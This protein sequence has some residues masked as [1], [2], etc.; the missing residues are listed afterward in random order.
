MNVNFRILWLVLCLGPTWSIAQS[1]GEQH[2]S[3]IQAQAPDG[4][5]ATDVAELTI[6]DQYQSQHNG[7]THLYAKQEYQGIAVETGHYSAHFDAEGRLLV[8]HNQLEKNLEAR[9]PTTQPT[10]TAAQAIAVAAQDLERADAGPARLLKRLGGEAQEAQ[11]QNEQLSTEPIPVQLSFLADRTGQMH[12]AWQLRL[13]LPGQ[14]HWWNYW[15]D[16]QDGSVVKRHDW[17][18]H[19]S[20]GDHS[21][22]FQEREAQA[23]TSAPFSPYAP[24]TLASVTHAQDGSSYRILPA[25]AESP[26]HGNFEL[27]SE[28]ADSLA[29]P[30]GWHDTDGQVGPEFTTTRGNNVYA[31]EDRGAANELTGYSPDGGPGLDF[32]FPYDSSQG[33]VENQDAAITNLFYWNNVMHDVWYHLGFDE[34]AGNFQLTNYGRGGTGG[35]PVVADAQDG[36]GFNNANFATPPDGNA[37]RMQMFIWNPELSFPFS[38]TAPSSLAGT[39]NSQEAALGPDLT[40]IPLEGE[41]VLMTSGGS[42]EGCGPADNPAELDGKI[43]LIRRGSCL[44]VDKILNAQDA[45]AIAV[46]MINNVNGDPIAMGGDDP[47]GQIRIPSLMITQR[48]GNLL[49][50]NLSDGPIMGALQARKI[51]GGFD[52]DFDN[53]VIAHE[54]AHGISNRLTG[55]PAEAFG[56]TNE[57]QA[58]EGWS[59]WFGLVVTHRPGDTRNTAR[60][61]ATYLTGERTTGNGI[62]P[63]RYSTD[64]ST[65]TLTYDDI[66]RLSVPHG[67]GSVMATMLWDL[68]W[69]LIDEYGF[70]PN[71]RDP[72]AGNVKAMQLVMDGLKLQAVSPGFTDVRD[73]ILLADEVNFNGAHHC[74]IWKTFARRGLGYSADQGSV[75]DRSDGSEAFDLPPLCQETIF[76]TNSNDKQIALPGDTLSYRVIW[77]N[78]TGADVPGLQVE[79]ELASSLNSL[80]LQGDCVEQVNGQ[81]LSF[82]P[83]VLLNE[84]RDTCFFLT[85]IDPGAPQSTYASIDE[86]EG[87]DNDRR[88]YVIESEV[89]TDAWAIDTTN[90]RSGDQ[91]YFVP[92]VGALNDQIMRLPLITV[93][94]KTVFSFWHYYDTESGWDGGFIEYRVFGT[95]EWKDLAPFIILNGYN[96]AVGSNNPVG[97]R[98]AFGGNSGGYLRTWADLSSFEGRRLNVRLRFVSDDNTSET[99]WWVD[100]VALIDAERIETTL[101]LRNADSIVT[102]GPQE[103]LTY[104]DVAEQTTNL[105]SDPA[106]G[107]AWKVFPNPAQDRLY[108]SLRQDD[109]QPLTLRL[110]NAMGQQVY[111]AAPVQALSHRWEVD[112][113]DLS[114]GMYVVSVQQGEK[115]LTRKLRVE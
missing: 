35:D 11:Y 83:G 88:N 106:P 77:S 49:I 5:K 114:A 89:G 110:F 15:V 46:V 67:V 97:A 63:Q 38:V 44:F 3:Q 60:G 30:F 18:T 87:D 33:P 20:W 70:D 42:A 95:S 22:P 101:C 57:E 19:C 69:N 115:L 1:L 8:A 16:A 59:D 23:H 111:E 66:K 74:M 108:V 48:D 24:K 62:R 28:P 29:S 98:P 14:A 7:V 91:A 99:G 61:I 79:G 6:T 32:D 58:G 2:L 71:L 47:N 100:D 86:L 41:L 12:L 105:Q 103:Q 40:D 4:L 68:Y 21:H 45:G 94:E 9:I 53:G 26:N 37:P 107:T 80:P 65:N 90:P 51:R 82:N 72:E 43:A 54:Y 84:R 109:V 78:R 17:V 64:M 31:L 93:G 55:G 34:A 113:Q 76:L 25:P 112:L 73:A 13:Y 52:S 85:E 50:D 39:Y 10:L 81:T 104:L 27:V 96:S 92:N 102:C 36:S 75:N 56:L